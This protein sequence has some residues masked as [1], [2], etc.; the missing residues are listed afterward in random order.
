MHPNF[1]KSF[2]FLVLFLL[3]SINYAIAGKAPIKYGKPDIEDLKMSVYEPDSTC[4]AVIL[5]NYGHFNA[6][7]F[8]FTQTLRV[9]ILKQSGTHWANK[10]FPSV[11]KNTFVRGKTFNLENGKIVENKLKGESIFKE[12]VF[13]DY[14][15]INIAM[16][17]VKVGSVI[18]IQVTSPGLPRKWRFQ[19]L[20]PVKW[21]ELVIE[22]SEYVNYQKNFFG[23]I[24][25]NYPSTNHWTV[26][27]VPAF[28]VEPYM[29]SYK[30]YIS[31]L[32]FDIK[33]ISF[34][35]FYQEFATTWEQVSGTL[36]ESDYFGSILRSGCV[37][38]KDIA[39]EIESNCST[40]KEKLQQAFEKIKI[41]KWNE[42]NSETTSSVNLNSV[43]KDKIG[44]SADINFMLIKLLK[45]LDLNAYPVI[46]STRSNGQLSMISPSLNK[47]N[48]VI[49]CVE[50]D[51]ERI[52]A[53]PTEENLPLGLIPERAINSQGRLVL[54]KHK[55]EWIKL[56]T[57]RKD[58]Q[59]AMYNLKLEDDNTITGK[60]TAIYTEYAAYSKREEL[61]S[62]NSEE[63]YLAEYESDHSGL[64]ILS[65]DL[66]NK[67][68]IYERFVEEWS[69][70]LKRHVEVVGDLTMINLHMF[71]QEKENIF[72]T[73]KR[74]YPVNY[75]Y[76]SSKV[77]TVKLELPDSYTVSE[78][79]KPV[80]LV[81]P[82]K[83]G[84]FTVSYSVQENY[85]MMSCMVNIKQKLFLPD[86]Y[87]Y[88]KEF[89]AQIVKKHAE[90]IILKK[91]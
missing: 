83:G 33:S 15:N 49:C 43:Y 12:R 46:M 85:I 67:E 80:R 34:P 86:E 2:K 74:I 56:S 64:T 29:D 30:N 75:P 24:S 77:S 47:L 32:E 8:E 36:Y 54:S 9:K 40:D 35:G 84:S 18:D 57:D 39:Q 19:E 4:E 14:Y 45:R 50:I 5:C 10:S 61:K 69:I 78:L 72:K 70:K 31:K 53:D 21:S 59:Q 38:L 87:P 1:H 81:L 41:V 7:D 27:N 25:L 62:Y 28:K 63:D 13:G 71:E 3:L 58:R 66:K 6:N 51:G 82:N 73:D 22:E 23:Y 52:L 76:S 20:I 79:P 65:Y 11:G 16:P 48:Y 88:L 17:N 89:F 91:I 68:N 55:T 44:N 26:A 37:F 42:K 60:R 90:P